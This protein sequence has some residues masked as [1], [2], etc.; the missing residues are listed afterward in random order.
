MDSKN[1]TDDEAKVKWCP[2]V[3]V[4]NKGDTPENRLCQR[5][6]V[7]QTPGEGIQWNCC[8]ASDCMMWRWY[9]PEHGAA[10]KPLTGHC[11]LA[12]QP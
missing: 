6:L 5:G 4:S 2:M 7:A 3:R 9:D 12:G 8:I 11:G 10:G 1:R